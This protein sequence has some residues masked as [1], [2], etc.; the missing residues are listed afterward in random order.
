M[1]QE[2]DIV[3]RYKDATWAPM[4]MELQLGQ[5]DTTEDSMELLWQKP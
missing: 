1:L 3:V 4:I 5:I 2:E